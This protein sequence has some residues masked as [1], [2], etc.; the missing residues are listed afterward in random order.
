MDP[1]HKEST[2]FAYHL[3]MSKK[4]L[5]LIIS[6]III[7]VVFGAI[8]WIYKKN[9]KPKQTQIEK[10]VEAV[11]QKAAS[12][13]TTDEEKQKM[14]ETLKKQE[15]VTVSPEESKTADEDLVSQFLKNQ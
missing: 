15:T 13:S 11:A 12:I 9:Q 2:S 14:L 8:F 4:T 6:G 3:Y 1:I 5:S 7:L 10:S